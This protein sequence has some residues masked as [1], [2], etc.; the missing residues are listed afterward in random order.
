MISG[1]K[2]IETGLRKYLPPNKRLFIIN[3]L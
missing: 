1:L 2:D 3:K